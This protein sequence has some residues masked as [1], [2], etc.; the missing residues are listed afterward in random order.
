M[1]TM[2]WECDF[3]KVSEI[4]SW[5][6]GY[7]FIVLEQSIGRGNSG[8]LEEFNTEALQI[9]NEGERR[10]NKWIWVGPQPSDPESD[11]GEG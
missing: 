3:A 7:P 5:A 11:L 10:N 4:P 2:P 8:A 6:L 1:A 9:E